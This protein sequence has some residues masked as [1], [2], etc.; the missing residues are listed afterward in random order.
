V[1]PA[2][3]VRSRTA[4]GIAAVAAL[5][6]STGSGGPAPPAGPPTPR[7]G[8][9]VERGRYLA[10]D[11]AMCVQ[12]HSPREEDGRIIA[13]QEFRGAPMPL[14]SPYPAARFA[15]K[16]PNLRELALSDPEAIVRL[17][18]TGIARGGKAPDLPM[19]PFRMTAEDADSIALYL[20]SLD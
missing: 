12:C 4:L 16:T 7:P 2:R 18:R 17:L 9:S 8:V 1:K 5:V 10:H 6:L 3:A 20:R 13:S 15:L 11:V 14:V 19:P